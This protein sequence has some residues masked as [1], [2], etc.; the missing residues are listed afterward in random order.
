V[1]Q[2]QKI[3]TIAKSWFNPENPSL[4]KAIELTIK[5]GLFSKADI[6]FQLSVLRENVANGEIEEWAK[7]S[8]VSDQYQAKEKKVLCLHAGNLPLVG[9]Q[10][11][12]G[13]ILSG[14]D[15]YGKLSRKDPWLL[16]SFLD[17]LKQ[18]GLEHEIQYSTE[19][20]DFTNLKAGRI[21]FAGSEESVSEVK[22]EILKLNASKKDADYIIRTAKFSIAY[23]DRWND[24]IK[25][26]LVQSMLR[27]GGRGCRSVAI[28]VADF[29]LDEVKRELKHAVQE[30]W[31]ENPQH[32]NPTPD[33]QY[34][35]AYNEAVQR[36]QLWMENFLIQ[37]SEDLPEVDFTVN[38]VEGG[39][40]KV[41]ELKASFGAKVQSVYT[42]GNEIE[43][44]N[45]E[46]LSKA[47]SPPLFWKPDGVDVLRALYTEQTGES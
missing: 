12:L 42:V 45:I 41:R 39:M 30:F 28:V 43:G 36:N 31:K 38:W 2:T 44:L 18:A 33:F 40:E 13:T 10:T 27:Y 5:Q 46:K 22:R 47:Q 25:D 32:Q 9:F 7:R 37:E 4:R 1:Q 17:E 11:A 35:Y 6:E 3:A 14:V 24:Q 8:S 26:E 19:L 21:V 16:A 15:Y 29:G 34:Q 20:T 23:L